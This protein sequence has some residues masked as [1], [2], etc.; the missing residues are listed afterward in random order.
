MY[1]IYI[2]INKVNNK[3]YVGQTKQD[4]CHRWWNGEGYKPKKNGMSHF[5]NAIKKYGWDNFEHE[6][7]YSNISKEEACKIEIELIEKY[8]TQDRNFGYNVLS[9]GTAPSV[10][11]EIRE[12][13]SKA[14]MG[15]KNGLGKP[16]SEE[17]KRKISEAQKGRHLTE[18]HKKKLSAAKKG[19]SHKPL[20]AESRK[21]IADAH[22]KNPVYCFETNTVYP[23]IQECARQLKLAATVVCR[24][25][26]GKLKSTSGYHFQYAT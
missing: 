22:K 16:C 7:L 1:K 8:K 23:S 9:G 2:H 10:P 14:L 19:K 20:S 18:D 6:I 5:Y 24:V 11:I 12:K 17:K 13:M 4:C 25:C 3:K 26:K 21:K 15:N